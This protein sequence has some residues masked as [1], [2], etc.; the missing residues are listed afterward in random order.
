MHEL[1]AEEWEKIKAID[2]QRDGWIEVMKQSFHKMDGEAVNWSSEGRVPTCR[3]QQGRLMRSEHVGTTAVVA[4]VG[5]MR[6]IVANCGD[7]RAVLSRNGVPVPLSSDHKVLQIY[8][9]RV[10]WHYVGSNA[11]LYG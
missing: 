6:I 5:P 10:I 4:V 1:V 7:S 2:A 3:C 11:N 9:S 8:S